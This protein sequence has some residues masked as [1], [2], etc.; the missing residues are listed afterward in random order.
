ML[1]EYAGALAWTREVFPEGFLGAKGSWQVRHSDWRGGCRGGMPCPSFPPAQGVKH[2]V[3]K[4]QC[5]AHQ[6]G[7]GR[8]HK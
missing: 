5:L 6:P 7:C 3:Q 1:W 8:L 4:N 2:H